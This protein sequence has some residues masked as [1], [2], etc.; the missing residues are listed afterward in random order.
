MDVIAVTTIYDWVSAPVGLAIAAVIGGGG[1]TLARRWD[2]EH[3]G[4]L[5][6]VPLIVLAPVV[7]DGITLLLVG[8]MLALSAAAL[9]VQL[10][11]D[12]IWMHA[13]RTAA[14][15][16]PL[17]MALA[18]SAFDSGDDLW[19]AAACGIAAVLA[20][21][22]A[23]ILLPRTR[24]QV[25][26][27]LLTAAGVLPVLCVSLAVD[28]VIAAL[29]AAALAAALLAIVCLGDR[30]PDVGGVVCQIWSALSAVSALVAVT[31]AFDGRSGGAG[32]AGDGRRGGRRR[33]PR[34]HR[35][36]GGVRVR[37]RRRRSLCRLRPAER[38]GR[39]H[40]DDHPG[41]GVDA[42]VECAAGGLRRR[43]R[44]GRG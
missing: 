35:Q 2:S 6:L 13:A 32:A 43:D 29:M 1:L 8:F 14:G 22:G 4:L 27:A 37:H 33:A 10:G 34:R 18:A 7:T 5:V 15:T 21:V 23:L 42:G 19:L 26:M 30:L 39:G 9:P 40:R 36:V 3:L 17:L 25:A 16:F 31:V 12:W 20:I 24:N 11:K 41:R 44:R 28:R 38:V